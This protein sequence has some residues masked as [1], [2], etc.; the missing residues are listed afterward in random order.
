LFAAFLV[1]E[2]R[3]LSSR[4]VPGGE[5]EGGKEELKEGK[6]GSVSTLSL[7]SVSVEEPASCTDLKQNPAQVS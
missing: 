3:G 1:L 6:G 4:I 2:A 7:D 5:G